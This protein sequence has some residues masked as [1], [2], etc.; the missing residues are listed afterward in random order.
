MTKKKDDAQEVQKP[1]PEGTKKQG[2]GAQEV[3]DATPAPDVLELTR[4][5]MQRDIRNLA[6][7]ADAR[8]KPETEQEAAYYAYLEE[9]A[10]EVQ[11]ATDKEQ[12]TFTL[13]E[14]AP[15]LNPDSL[16]FDIEAYKKAIEEAGGFP[17]LADYLDK[18]LRD[19]YGETMQKLAA[20]GGQAAAAALAGSE[21]RLKE[22]GHIAATAAARALA[23]NPKG[24]AAA[25]AARHAGLQ[26][27]FEAYKET[28][29]E[30]QKA[31]EEI[32]EHREA[33][34]REQWPEFDDAPDHIKIFACFLVGDFEAAEA[35]GLDLEGLN[36]A[37][38]MQEG[39]TSEW[40]PIKESPYFELIER[41]EDRAL[42]AEAA[43]RFLEEIRKENATGTTAEELQKVFA[44]DTNKLPIPLD[45]VNQFELWGFNPW[46]DRKAEGKQL[47]FEAWTINESAPAKVE[48]VY[49]VDFEALDGLKLS[50]P[51]SQYDKRVYIAC[52]GI[53]S[54]GGAITS[55]RQIHN[56]MGGEGNP[57]PNQRK[58]ILE[59]LDKMSITKVKI[60]NDKEVQAYK[61][62]PALFAREPP[63]IQYKGNLISI[64]S[65]TAII[66][67]KETD[68]VHILREPPLIS[69]ARARNEITTIKR[70]VLESPQSKTEQV[71]AIQDYLIYHIKRKDGAKTKRLA[72]S[73]I[74]DNCGITSR[75][76]RQNAPKKIKTELQHYKSTG[77]IEGFKEYLAN[78]K[79]AGVEITRSPQSNEN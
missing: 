17:V 67:G 48:F 22:I 32:R 30:A 15:E 4:K 39:F 64:E 16:Q 60:T 53:Y 24:I 47:V 31:F 54:A 29:E 36:V 33:A 55:I 44:G 37:Q 8:E 61:E 62:N 73:T 75:T 71:I 72:Y 45:R 23:M 69:F 68:A 7:F 20:A 63:Q 57:A 49:S 78:G 2:K 58:K 79:P 18:T 77:F 19:D 26:A 42:N 35:E 11:D 10:Q 43:R 9:H 27:A 21:E 6:G 76:S 51:F 50:Q 12:L 46:K 1:T 3:Q 74:C 38:I 66:K 14:V 40:E 56:A 65:V 59:S 41:V 70:E 52:A 28:A 13:P 5:A 25:L 34:A